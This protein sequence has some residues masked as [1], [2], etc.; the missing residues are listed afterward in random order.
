MAKILIKNAGAIVTCDAEDHVYVHSDLL[1]EDNRIVQIGTGIHDEEARCIHAEGKYV[2]PGL[3]NTH[4]HFF[5]A[6]V[7]NLMSI[8][9]PGLTLIQWLDEIYKVFACIDSDVI[10]FAS[11]ACM[12]DLIKHGCTCSVDH[13]YCYTMLTGKTP[14]DRQMEAADLLGFRLIAARGTNTLPRSKGSTV[15]DEMC[16][17]TGEY[18]RDCERLI[19]RY[20]DPHP[21]AMH[22]IVLAPCQPINCEEDTFRETIRLARSAGVYMHT[23][24]CEG[25]NRD[26]I[27]RFG[28]RSLAWCEKIG[29][30]GPDIWVAHG[31][32]TLPEEYAFLAKNGMGISH[33]PAPTIYG[34]S[35]ILDI[36]GMT[37]AGIPISL[38]VD[39]CS[40]NE[41]SS[42]LD[43]IR[44]A[45][46]MQAFLSKQ[47]GGCPSPYDM[48]KI[49]TT[50]GARMVGRPELGELAAG[51][52]AD[53]FMIDAGRLEYAGALHDPASIIPK[54]GITGNVWLTMI[55]GKI[56]YQDDK[57]VGIDEKELLQEGERVCTKVL[58]S[59]CAAFAGY[60]TGLMKEGTNGELP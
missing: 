50:A 36:P 11:I 13:Q 24:L 8:D 19:E 44:L 10:Y 42:M 41:G 27:K 7:R 34:G 57:L 30:A 31:R 48:M 26:M 60:R 4:H 23:H 49:S 2:Y 1:I 52:A 40:T 47:R 38:G 46:L 45:Y 37:R 9:R 5:Q 39:G 14:V 59:Q 58:R 25:E 51:K 6:F 32:E 12:A 29:F 54:L 43:S 28:M 18:I 22:Q 17:T 55:N 53:L 35:E 16:E 20:H 21:F 15:P 56:V 3:V 33:C